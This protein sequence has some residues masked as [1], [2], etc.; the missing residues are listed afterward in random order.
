MEPI[1]KL[2]RSADLP[3]GSPG[4]VGVFGKGAEVGDSL[5][6]TFRSWKGFGKGAFAFGAR[7]LGFLV[8]TKYDRLKEMVAVLTFVLD[9]RHEGISDFLKTNGVP[10]LCAGRLSEIYNLMGGTEVRLLQPP[11]FI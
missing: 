7:R 9:G 1:P 2:N 4:S 8:P 11:F 10:V 3:Q 6:E 5:K